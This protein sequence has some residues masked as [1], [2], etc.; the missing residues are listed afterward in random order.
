MPTSVSAL[1]LAAG[2]SSRFGKKNKLFEMLGNKPLLY[3]PLRTFE[4]NKNIDEIILV[5][6][7]GEFDRCRYITEAYSFK[8][9]N[10]TIR[11]GNSRQESSYLGLQSI[12]SD[13]VLIH[14]AARPF[15]TQQCINN[16]IENALQYGA[17]VLLHPSTNTLKEVDDNGFIKKTLDRSNV[18]ETQT[19]QA[20]RLAI[21]KDAHE[22]ARRDDF[23]S[24]D[25]SSLVE[26]LSHR[27]KYSLGSVNNIK[28]TF[29]EDLEYARYLLN[30]SQIKSTLFG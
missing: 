5:A 6:K 1:I 20:F 11:G 3:Y 18:Y 27:V 23:E 9:I 28:I 12:D 22:Q 14:D 8:K 15:V 2:Y 4:T 17:S 29:P 24:P 13:I 16:L 21:I 7:G 26:R 10:K 25:D 30:T 19:P